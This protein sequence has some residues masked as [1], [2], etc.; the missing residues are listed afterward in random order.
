ML[1]RSAYITDMVNW[2]MQDYWETPLE[3]MLNQGDCEDYAIAKYMLLRAAGLPAEQMRIVIL[4]DINLNEM[5]AI[6]VVSHEGR[7]LV[8]DNFQPNVVDSRRIVH[9][10]P[11][12]ALNEAKWWRH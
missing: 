9:Y 5:H 1:N 11:I 7:A 8:L 3:F 6:L 12:Y 2:G 4:Q 10:R